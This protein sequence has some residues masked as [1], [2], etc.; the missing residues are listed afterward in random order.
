M[1]VGG[2]QKN[3]HMVYQTWNFDW[4]ILE[5]FNLIK[6]LKNSQRLPYELM[7]Y[8]TDDLSMSPIQLCDNDQ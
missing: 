8:V 6:R 1:G 7:L 5:N 2:P 4:H 3:D